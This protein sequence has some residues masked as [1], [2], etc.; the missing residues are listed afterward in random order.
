MTEFA[1]IKIERHRD[2][3]G[4]PTCCREW[5]RVQCRFIGVRKFGTVD[6]CQLT[7]DDLTRD[8]NGMGWIRPAFG[9]PVWPQQPDSPALCTPSSP[10]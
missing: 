4:H 9:C 5:G 7:G 2:P 3:E 6:V 10:V 8:R 1:T